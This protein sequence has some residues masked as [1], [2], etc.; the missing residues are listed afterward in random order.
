MGKGVL[1]PAGLLLCA[2]GCSPSTA[3]WIDQARAADPAKRLRAIHVLQQKV[4]EKEAVV[5]VLTAAL[6]DED[7]YVRRDAA[8][9]LGQF[10]AAARGAVPALVTC[11]ADKQPSVRRA[12]AQS[13]K[14]IDP[15]AARQAGAR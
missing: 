1:L 14:Q 4:Q 11:L 12:A 8:R 5:P 13:L 15:G 3:D 10:G 9:A 6:K 7:T 2:L